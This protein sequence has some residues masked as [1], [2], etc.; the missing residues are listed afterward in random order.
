MVAKFHRNNVDINGVTLLE[1]A[2]E[3]VKLIPEASNFKSFHGLLKGFK[4]RNDVIR[5][6]L[7]GEASSSI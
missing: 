5:L 7:K 1:R 3:F 2:S 6:S 4:N